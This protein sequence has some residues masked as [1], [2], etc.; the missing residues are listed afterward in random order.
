MRL[1]FALDLLQDG[2]HKKK[3]VIDQSLTVETASVKTYHSRDEGRFACH[4]ESLQNLSI[5][6][7]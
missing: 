6:I 2:A 4:G 7:C 5:L 3:D 1:L